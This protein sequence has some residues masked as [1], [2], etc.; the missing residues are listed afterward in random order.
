MDEIQRGLQAQ[1][2]L[3][4]QYL[5]DALNALDQQYHAAW[6]NAKTV[7]AREDCHRYVCLIEKLVADLQSTATTGK[8]KEARLK[9]L[10]GAKR[11]IFTWPTT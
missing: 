6:R 10:E 5:R 9:E 4:N 8:L 2:L 1:A 11:S 7:E 3:E